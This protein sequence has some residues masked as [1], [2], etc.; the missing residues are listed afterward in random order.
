MRDGGRAR[1]AFSRGS[2]SEL[3]VG[4]ALE[5]SGRWEVEEAE[6]YSARSLGYYQRWLRRHGEREL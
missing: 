1:L 4:L 6:P 2:E 5:R 3:C